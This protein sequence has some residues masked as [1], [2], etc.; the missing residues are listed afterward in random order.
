MDIFFFGLVLKLWCDGSN[1]T[2]AA[3]YHLYRSLLGI[4]PNQIENQIDIAYFFFKAFVFVVDG[5]IG[6]KLFYK[7]QVFCRFRAD[8]IRAFPFSELNG[9]AAYPARCRVN[10][11]PLTFL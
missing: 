9:K 7:I 1:N 6:T 10:E 2:S 3:C 11:P 5:F 8:N 4:F